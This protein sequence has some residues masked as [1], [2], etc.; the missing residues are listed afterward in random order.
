V[1]TISEPVAENAAERI[2]TL[3]SRARENPE[4]VAQALNAWLAASRGG[5]PPQTVPFRKAA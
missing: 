1:A 5:E 3:A 2:A 4:A